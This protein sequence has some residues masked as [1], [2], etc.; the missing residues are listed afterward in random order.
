MVKTNQV[1]Q[2]LPRISGKSKEEQI[3]IEEENNLKCYAWAA[4][5]NV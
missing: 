1:D 4:E 2:P 5:N 3:A